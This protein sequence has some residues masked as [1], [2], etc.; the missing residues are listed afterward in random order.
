MLFPKLLS[1]DVC[2]SAFWAKEGLFPKTH[3]KLRKERKAPKSELEPNLGVLICVWAK[4]H[5]SLAVEEFFLSLNTS[6]LV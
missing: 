6:T 5:L 4:L 1:Q 3:C 2:R